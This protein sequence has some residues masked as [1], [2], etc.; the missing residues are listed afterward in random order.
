MIL[1]AGRG[2]RMR[3]L[4]DATPKPLLRVGGRPL[5]D[6]HLTALARAG[7]GEVVVNVAWL[8]RQLV[9]YLG[10]GRRWGL[11]VAISDEG[12]QALET[13]GG[14]RR[15]LP[16]L[17]EEPFWVMNGDVWSDFDP[18]ALPRRPA[19]LAHL[20]LV[21]NPPHNPA[22][23]FSLDAAGGVGDSGDRRLTFAGIGCYAPALFEHAGGE[24]AF[25]LA[26]LLRAAAAAGQVTGVRHHGA[27]SDVGTPQRLRSLDRKL[28]ARG[29]V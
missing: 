8:G 2:Q 4:T 13:G 22:G 14:I 23:D 24:D 3:P 19:G 28:T 1:A 11:R 10:D 18:A 21:D 20:L 12:G 9:E 15:A 16:L 25:P 29:G 27:W 26:P 17:G 6:W 7:V 5:I